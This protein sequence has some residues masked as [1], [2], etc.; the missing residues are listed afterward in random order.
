MI[1]WPFQ[2]YTSQTFFPKNHKVSVT[3]RWS[4]PKI[5]LHAKNQ[6]S[7]LKISHF[8]RILMFWPFKW[9]TGQKFFPKNHKVRVTN[10]WSNPKISLHAKNQLSNLKISHFLRIL[11]FWPFKWYTGQKFFPKNHKVRL[12]NRWSNPK[13][14]LHAK[15]QLYSLK[16]SRFTDVWKTQNFDA[17]LRDRRY[18]FDQTET[19][20]NIV[21]P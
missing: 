8:L 15:N 7:N 21:W 14:S 12:T 20:S 6:L 9:Y 4:N 3:N 13:I 11:M 18:H 1:F 2:W 10:R 16:I 5:S 17:N 19:H